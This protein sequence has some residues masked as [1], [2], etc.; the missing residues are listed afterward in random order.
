MK[1][2]V[3][4]AVIALA[5]TAAVF[6]SARYFGKRG[7][8]HVLLLSGNM[9]V[10]ETNTGFKPAGRVI[11]LLVD[12]GQSVRK[13]DLLAR[14]DDAEAASVVAQQRA[15]LQE[16]GARLAELEAGS[17]PQEIEQAKADVQTQEAE[18][19]R[20][21]KDYERAEMLYHN[22][23]I[24]SAQFDAAKSAF[25]SRAAQ[26]CRAAEQLSLTKEGPRKE[27]IEAAAYRVRQARAQLRVVE[28]KLNDTLIYAPFSGVILRKNV[29]LGETVAQG[30][31]VYTIG[32]LANP[33]IKVY[34]KEDKL[35]LVKLGQK[36]QVTTDTYRGKVYNGWVSFISSEAEFTPKNVQTQEERV[37]LVFGVK[38]LVENVN[39]ELK[40]SMPADVRILL[41]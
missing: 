34:V 4:I 2:S 27:S 11:D 20:I 35:G 24:P 40:P 15:A 39:N 17:R 16:A 30:V 3:A 29:E 1:K 12:E 10:T 25:E 37:K 13:G 38:V 32:D 9:E 23:A 14:L 18:L 41:K 28:E 7:E 22:G 31:P 26:L 5:A 36:A 33:W 19:V 21:K 6:L 8:E